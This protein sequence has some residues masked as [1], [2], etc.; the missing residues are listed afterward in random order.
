MAKVS[1]TKLGLKV[2]ND[3]NIINWND[4]EI[5]VKKYLPVNT[6]L[7][8]ISNVIN[9]CA[10]DEKF[11]N[12]GKLKIYFTLEVIYAYT[13]INFTDKQKEDECKLFDMFESS[14][15]WNE[16]VSAIG[17]EEIEFLYNT[18]LEAI[19]AIYVYTNSVMGA[20]DSITRDYSNLDL[21]ASAIQS[22]LADPE[23]LELLKSI[24]TKLG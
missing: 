24:L 22:K 16:I 14:G 19:D 2:N 7:E 6:K 5:E 3:I 12:I 9:S 23:N 4:Q 10:E 1:F 20:I 11:Y 21:D 15:L 8:L 18:A 13:N 17:E